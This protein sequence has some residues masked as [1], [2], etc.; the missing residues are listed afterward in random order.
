MKRNTIFM[1]SYISFVSICVILRL[2]FDFSL[3]NSVVLSITLSS[4]FFSVEDLLRSQSVSLKRSLEIA[5]PLANSVIESIDKDLQFFSEAD[6]IMDK[7]TGTAYDLGGVREMFKSS[8]A[9]AEKIKK[10]A[11]NMYERSKEYRKA[12]EK[13]ARVAD[14]LVYFGFLCLFCTLIVTSF[15]KIPNLLQQILTVISFTIILIT[16]QLNISAS[17]RLAEEN[18]ASQGVLENLQGTTES[19]KVLQEKFFEKIKNIEANR[20]NEKLLLED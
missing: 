6:A 11:S 8:R 3:W 10:T 13:Y 18:A 1:W 20:E 5:E 17:E 14:V 9:D 12:E 16:Q 4:M 2:F 7:Y 19:S 15:I